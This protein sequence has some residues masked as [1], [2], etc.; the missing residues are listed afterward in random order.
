MALPSLDELFP[1]VNVPEQS[2]VA[3]AT[4]HSDAP[5]GGIVAVATEHS[6]APCV[7]E[8]P[9]PSQR[10]FTLEE[11]ATIWQARPDKDQI[12]T[13][14]RATARPPPIDTARR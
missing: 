12:H 13:Q 2:I 14:M 7:L 10:I 9:P 6:D 5:V 1:L 11:A 4:E 3:V 8:S